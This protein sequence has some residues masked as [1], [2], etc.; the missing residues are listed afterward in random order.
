MTAPEIEKRGV[1]LVDGV[2]VLCHGTVKVLLKLDHRR[3]LAF[4]TLQGE[5][6]A[7]LLKNTPYE[8]APE[9]MNTVIYVRGVGEAEPSAYDRSTAV[10]MALKDMGGVYGLIS[11]L[12]VLPRPLRDAVY[13]GVAQRRYRWFGRHDDVCPFPS[14]DDSDRFLP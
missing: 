14:Q 7:R 11:W 1:L 8:S 3:R 4:S 5:T 12:R 9:A 13:D 2:C 10:L 6:A